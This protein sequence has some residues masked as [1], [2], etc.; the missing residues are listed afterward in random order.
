MPVINPRDVMQVSLLEKGL[1][2]EGVHE[3]VE[4]Q[5]SGKGGY[6]QVEAGKGEEVFHLSEE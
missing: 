2:V 1:A 6:G 5:K 3:E 4:R